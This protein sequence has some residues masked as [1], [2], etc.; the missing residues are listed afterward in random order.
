[1]SFKKAAVEKTKGHT[2]ECLLALLAGS[3]GLSVIP[4]FLAA[5]T[6]GLTRCRRSDAG[7]GANDFNRPA[8]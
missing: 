4:A 1:M 6:F 2:Q 7:A 8:S 5:F 3:S